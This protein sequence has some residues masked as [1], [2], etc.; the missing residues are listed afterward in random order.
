MLVKWNPIVP[1]L[2]SDVDRAFLNDWFTDDRP[3]VDFAPR[4]DVAENK[5][6]FVVRAELPGLSK[7]DVKITLDNQIL[8]LSGEKRFEDEKKD[9]NYHLRET[10]Y[11]KFARR[12][13]LTGDIDRGHIQAAYKDGV[14]E[15]T[16]P[17]TK[18][19]H[20]LLS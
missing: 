11:G 14:L 16:L 4:V 20:R 8:T 17:K 19:A 15:I 6:S 2:F 9:K 3:A 12:F 18:E 7:D 1:R 5:E 13:R 10:C